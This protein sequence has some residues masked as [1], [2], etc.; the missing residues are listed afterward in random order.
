MEM[1]KRN[2]RI[3]PIFISDILF[4]LT[5]TGGHWLYSVFGCVLMLGIILTQ[6][7]ESDFYCFVTLIPFADGVVIYN[8]SFLSILIFI[9]IL[10]AVFI[11]RKNLVSRTNLL[12]LTL[13]GLIILTE[14]AF[15][16]TFIGFTTFLKILSYLLYY[17]VYCML[18]KT[19]EISRNKL[20]VC[21]I[22]SLMI[23]LLATLFL[24]GGMTALLS[25]NAENR[26]GEQV[27][28]LGGAMG[29]PVYCLLIISMLLYYIYH[30]QKIKHKI[31]Y[32]FVILIVGILG[33][34]T[35]S[36]LYL[37]GLGVIGLF[38]IISLFNKKYRKLSFFFLGAIFVCALLVLIIYPEFYFEKVYIMIERLLANFTTGRDDIYISC[39]EFLKEHP[40]TLL[41]GLGARNYIE[42]GVI[43]DY[44]FQKMAHNLLLDGIMAW[45]ILGV[46]AF[47]FIT[48]LFI[49]KGI[50]QNQVKVNLWKVLPFV[51]WFCCRMTAGTFYYFLEYMYILAVTQ[52]CF[53][54]ENQS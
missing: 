10:K 23:A 2:W 12:F 8:T 1:I 32:L 11:N 16:L 5:L 3:L 45:G 42:V 28:E 9:S 27:R 49:K 35:L 39:F 36:K 47:I 34:F 53:L 51:I 38:F 4:C 43:G 24:S 20:T 50:R 19:K 46:S 26:F 31:F 7:F 17:V 22:G 30:D 14:I 48:A 41:F 33:F 40:L 29:I 18:G 13:M 37:F 6:D 21:F 52:F 15:D 54:N 25:A 44:A